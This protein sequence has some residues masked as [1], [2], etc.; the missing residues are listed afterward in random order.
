MEWNDIELLTKFDL[1]T[2]AHTHKVSTNTNSEHQYLVYL[3][4]K[5]ICRCMC[6]EQRFGSLKC[7]YHVDPNIYTDM[8]SFY[9]PILTH[10]TQLDNAHICMSKLNICSLIKKFESHSIDR[11]T[12]V[13]RQYQQSFG[14]IVVCRKVKIK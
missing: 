3:Y 7:T 5:G 9:R 14:K 11:T 13:P 2:H 12:F 10:Q 6:K 4:Y 8:K 1:N